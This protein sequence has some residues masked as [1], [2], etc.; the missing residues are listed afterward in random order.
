MS[1]SGVTIFP[2]RFP[3]NMLSIFHLG[4]QF[5]KCQK[6]Q[7][8]GGC[9]FFLWHDEDGANNNSGVNHQADPNAPQCNCNLPTVKRTV[10]KDGPN[11]GRMFYSCPK[12]FQEKC[13]FF[14]WA[15]EVQFGYF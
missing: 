15:D 10:Q 4:R 2:G 3:S 11:K 14:Q 7:A 12:S 1:I 5:H 8:Q 13:N 6:G 9:D